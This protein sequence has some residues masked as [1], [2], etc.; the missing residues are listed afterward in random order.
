MTASV[1]DTEG[2]VASDIGSEDRQQSTIACEGMGDAG[3][4]LVE[5]ERL[6]TSVVTTPQNLV[7]EE[8]N[9]R[10]QGDFEKFR[11]CF[12]RDAI[13]NGSEQ[14]KICLKM[15]AEGLRCPDE[16]WAQ[17]KEV[18][19]ESLKGGTSCRDQATDTPNALKQ[20]QWIYGRLSSLPVPPKN[21]LQRLAE[22]CL[23]ESTWRGIDKWTFAVLR[24]MSSVD[25]PEDSRPCRSP[26]TSGR[27]RKVEQRESTL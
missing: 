20:R 19:V 3:H 15:L 13:A 9:A 1:A 17:T 8:E 21:G 4:A 2:R 7:K 12:D 18:L 11:D 16:Y 10:A 26:N 27:K 5:G 24:C 14:A 23:D 25:I 22:C 6:S